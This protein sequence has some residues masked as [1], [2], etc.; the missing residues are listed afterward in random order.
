M[1]TSL[2][3][4]PRPGLFTAREAARLSGATYRQLDYWEHTQ[5]L[6]PEVPAAGSGS[7]RYYRPSQVDAIKVVLPLAQHLIWPNIDEIERRILRGDRHA[8][9][10][11]DGTFDPGPDTLSMVVPLVDP[12]IS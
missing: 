3:A 5:R 10:G 11:L 8:V 7:R 12:Q 6:T 1:S 4:P 9:I 2:Q